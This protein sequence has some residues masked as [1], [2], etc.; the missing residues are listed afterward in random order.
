MHF[1]YYAATIPSSVSHCHQS[2]LNHFSGSFIPEKP[3]RPFTQA[4]RHKEGGFRVYHG[5]VNPHPFFVASGDVAEDG[6]DFVRKVYPLHRVARADV[7]F[8]FCELGGFD[9]M[10]KIIDPIARNARAAVTF[11]GDPSPGQTAGRTMYFGSWKSDVQVKVYEKGLEQRGKG[12]ADAPDD[13]I[14]VEL[15]TK[16]R[17]DRKARAATMDEDQLWGLSKWTR[18][19]LEKLDGTVVEYHPDRSMRKSTVERAID[20]MCVQYGSSMR[21]FADEHSAELLLDRIRDV[22]AAR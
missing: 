18:T 5:G 17:K 2:I 3:Q 22:L 19:A 20:H 8:D 7:A 11:L 10:V 6:K 9:R 16:P 4:V 13:W 14:R 21:T 1:D 15:K 12:V